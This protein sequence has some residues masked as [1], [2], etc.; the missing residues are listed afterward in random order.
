MNDD[1]IP[2]PV[3]FICNRNYDS[4]VDRLYYCI[5]DIAVCDDCINSVKKNN[6]SW[7]CPKCNEVNDIKE[8]R[9]IRP[10]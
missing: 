10:D 6:N 9:L 4:K 8:S 5:C 2:P 7:L 1:D 3:C